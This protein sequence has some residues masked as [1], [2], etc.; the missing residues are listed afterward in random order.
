MI[1]VRYESETIDWYSVADGSLVLLDFHSLHRAHTRS[2]DDSVIL[3]QFGRNLSAHRRKP[4]LVKRNVQDTGKHDQGSDLRR[5][6]VGLLAGRALHTA[7][8]P[9][10]TIA[11][12]DPF[13][14]LD[15]RVG[16]CGASRLA[17]RCSAGTGPAYRGQKL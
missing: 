9:T 14:C 6:H 10:F 1:S 17:W 8:A 5:H 13:V 3:F 12:P 15:E 11:V 7:G 16:Y 2:L 4:I